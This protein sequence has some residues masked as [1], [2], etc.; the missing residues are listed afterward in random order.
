M[1]LLILGCILGAV[2]TVVLEALAV[3]YLIVKGKK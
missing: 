1:I 2:I 3:Y